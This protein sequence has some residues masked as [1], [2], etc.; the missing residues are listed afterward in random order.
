M[1]K[2]KPTR[3]NIALKKLFASK[4]YR[5]W[6]DA[7]SNKYEEFGVPLPKEPI[8]EPKCICHQTGW[9]KEVNDKVSESQNS[10]ELKK[11]LDTLRD[12]DGRIEGHEKVQKAY[13]FEE[14]Y[15]LEPIGMYIDYLVCTH[16]DV[17]R[18]KDIRDR[19]IYSEFIR[20]KILHGA[21]EYVSPITVS[22]RPH[23]IGK[24][25]EKALWLKIEPEATKQDL[26]DSWD[27]VKQ[28]QK[29]LPDYKER[30]KQYPNLER[31]VRIM[32]I[33]N[34][35]K[36]SDKDKTKDELAPLP[37]IALRV[38]SKIESEGFDEIFE[39]TVN[40]I[41]SQSTSPKVRA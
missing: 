18:F 15:T 7:V 5:E 3:R 19:E 11:A 33:Y 38:A 28:W 8:P 25:Q 14:K 23:G 36:E 40:K 32:D 20:K 13:E 22:H 29:D 1:K 16:M 39:E 27:F 12:K 41:V 26:A 31:D 35:I 30:Y 10:P 24:R 6:F 21:D 2:P 34:E 17:D 4:A 37:S 9:Y